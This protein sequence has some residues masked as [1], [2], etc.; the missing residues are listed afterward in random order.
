MP[1]N[2]FLSSRHKSSPDP[3]WTRRRTPICSSGPCPSPTQL[4][5]SQSWPVLLMYHRVWQ[6][7]H[8][9]HINSIGK[10][11]ETAD[12]QQGTGQLVERSTPSIL[13]PLTTVPTRGQRRVHTSRTGSCQPIC[14]CKPCR[15]APANKKKKRHSVSRP[16]TPLALDAARIP[17]GAH[18]SVL[19]PGFPSQPSPVL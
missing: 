15:G 6:T 7:H 9:R 1:A 13:P 10:R 19:R 5:H 18:T 4:S 17:L 3:A 14:R 11:K 12:S 16:V 8:H 2:V